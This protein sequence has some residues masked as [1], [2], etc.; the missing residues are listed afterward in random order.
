MITATFDVKQ[1]QELLRQLNNLKGRI[2]NKILREESERAA[3]RHLILQ[4]ANA[5]PFK[6]GELLKSLKV[7]KMKRSRRGIGV[8]IGY[9]DEDFKG[10]TFYGAF[11]EYGW[12]SGK[13]TA[14]Q[15]RA[16]NYMSKIKNRPTVGSKRGRRRNPLLKLAYQKILEATD[17]R[18]KIPGRYMLKGV[19]ERHGPEAMDSFISETWKRI[20]VEAKKWR[21]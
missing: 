18:K 17:Q 12:R 13:R 9:G 19:A 14:E 6:T 21:T 1:S 8:R 2:R 15:L 11:L 20:E 4:A 10:D 7:R 3:N 16:Q 5:T